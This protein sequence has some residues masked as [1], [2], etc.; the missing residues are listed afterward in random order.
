[1]SKFLILK[2]FRFTIYSN[3]FMLILNDDDKEEM[4]D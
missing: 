4:D 2:V 1:M 3:R